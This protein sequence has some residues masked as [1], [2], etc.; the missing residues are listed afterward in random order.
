MQ[1]FY[2]H[3]SRLA[4][5]MLTPA[6]Y[7]YVFAHYDESMLRTF[8]GALEDEVF[9]KEQERQAAG[10]AM[11]DRSFCWFQLIDKERNCIIGTAGFHNWYISHRRA[12][13]GY[14]ITV[15]TYKRK[16][17]MTEAIEAILDYGF[18]CLHLH[19]VEAFVA[20][21]NTPSLKIMERFNFTREGLLRQHYFWNGR[22]EDSQAFGLLK[23]EYITHLI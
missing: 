12:E 9:E 15:E 8:L 21:Y 10:R 17:F 20:P 18:D 3:T 1:F 6:V 5:R 13:L 7:D 11:Y 2:L 19:R 23:A 14:G 22:H 4:L 16:G